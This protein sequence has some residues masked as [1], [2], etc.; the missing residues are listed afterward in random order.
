MKQITLDPDTW[1]KAL[2]WEKIWCRCAKHACMSTLTIT[3]KEL[4]RPAE[5]W[6]GKGERVTK[7]FTLNEVTLETFN[8][9]L[10]VAYP[11]YG[12]GFPNELFQDVIPPVEWKEIPTV[13]GMSDGAEIPSW[14]ERI[15]TVVKSYLTK[16]KLPGGCNLC[17]VK[18]GGKVLYNKAFGV[19]SITDPIAEP[20]TPQNLSYAASVSKTITSVAVMCCYEDG[21][22][23]L[24]QSI[25][26]ILCEKGNVKPTL[27]DERVAK[28]TVK[29][30]M[31]HTAGFSDGGG[32]GTVATL[33]TNCKAA[34]EYLAAITLSSDPGTNHE[35]NNLGPNLLGRVIEA[36]SGAEHYEQF[37]QDRVFKVLDLP[38]CNKYSD[39]PVLSSKYKQCPM[40]V[41]MYT[42]T[43]PGTIKDD[44]SNLY[45]KY[46]WGSERIAQGNKELG[47][48]GSG[49]WKTTALQCAAMGA[50]LYQALLNP[51]GSGK[52]F[53]KQTTAQHLFSSAHAHPSCEKD[54]SAMGWYGLGNI[55]WSP[56]KSKCTPEENNYNK[57]GNAQ[58][59]F[60]HGGTFG[61]AFHMG[62]NI[63]WYFS[64]TAQPHF[65]GDH[66]MHHLFGPNGEGLKDQ[67]RLL[68]QTMV[69]GEG[70]QF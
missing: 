41:P 65:N 64:L 48:G 25:F 69:Y 2:E 28:I 33:I 31:N 24:D 46:L 1:E 11:S 67:L 34:A 23:T 57:D 62:E 43:R 52:I 66:T 18:P 51:D 45:W 22:L 60:M 9:E 29:M 50:D 13:S 59:Q 14:H 40:E 32:M 47:M 6:F 27:K 68:I 30:C 39:L 42:P 63:A 55:G 44:L 26:S 61:S 56:D 20:M 12:Q 8:A 7:Y 16:Y 17:M 21:T 58:T 4:H 54:Y 10:S 15:D 53:K 36:V 19:K 5:P 37:V 70:L 49:G 38:K 3:N 35:Y